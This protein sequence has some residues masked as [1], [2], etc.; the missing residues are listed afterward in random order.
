MLPRAMLPALAVRQVHERVARRGDG[1]G[2]RRA[3]R[4]RRMSEFGSALRRSSQITKGMWHSVGSAVK[5]VAL[6]ALFAFLYMAGG[7]QCARRQ[8]ASTPIAASAE[9][10]EEADEGGGIVERGFVPIMARRADWVDGAYPRHCEEIRRNPRPYDKA[11][12]RKASKLGL[13]GAR[14]G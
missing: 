1:G 3:A 9:R 14:S 7:R 12:K 11:C 8:Q 4:G 10:A 5:A 2:E 6:F 13:R